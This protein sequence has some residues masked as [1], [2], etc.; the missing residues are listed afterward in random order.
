[1]DF[2]Q[3]AGFVAR[4][5]TTEALNSTTY[6]SVVYRDSIPIGF[7]FVSLH[8]VDVNAIDIEN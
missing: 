2:Q 1:M 7:L 4:G 8:G 3:Q 5:H 6:Y